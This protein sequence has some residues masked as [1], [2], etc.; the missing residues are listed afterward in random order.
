MKISSK[1][2]LMSYLIIFVFSLMT[3]TFKTSAITYNVN[4]VVVGDRGVGK[5]TL[6][7]Q[8]CTYGDNLNRIN[9]W[10]NRVHYFYEPENE[11]YIINFYE[12]DLSA[13]KLEN[14]SFQSSTDTLLKSSHIALI[15]FDLSE[16]NTLSKGRIQRYKEIVKTKS[17]QNLAIFIPN[18]IDLL[19]SKEERQK[20]GMP[21]ADYAVDCEREQKYGCKNQDMECLPVSAIENINIEHLINNICE[22]AIP[23]IRACDEENG[24]YD[25][26]EYIE[27][28]DVETKKEL[29]RKEL[30]PQK[31]SVL[32]K[33]LELFSC[34]RS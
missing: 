27:V 6:I 1:C 3:L 16:G 8:L 25:R 9:E 34:W 2:K 26:P 20:F 7:N 17:P 12:I 18:K 14:L 13:E 29:E 15:V 31:K 22:N 32:D 4:V 10:H 24:F 5:T 33:L 11:N 28:E 19:S 21:I 23:R 30:V